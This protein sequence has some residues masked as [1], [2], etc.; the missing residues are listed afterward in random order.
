MTSLIPLNSTIQIYSTTSSPLIDLTS[1]P[2]V[3]LTEDDEE[4]QIEPE[5]AT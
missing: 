3:D 1:S 4:M 5:A 2:V